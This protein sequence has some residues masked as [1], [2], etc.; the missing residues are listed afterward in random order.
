MTVV[1]SSCWLEYFAGSPASDAYAAVIE[2]IGGVIVPTIVLYEVFKK[3]AAEADED[4]AFR[5]IAHMRQGVVADL[6]T[7]IALHAAR[8]GREYGLPL[9][10][11][12][13]YATALAHGAGL[14]THDG[15]FGSVPGVRFLPK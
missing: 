5:A 10:D 13:I 4:K 11:S 1:D 6:D 12:V 14:I 8:V 9:A 2:S 3:V 7:S 15:H